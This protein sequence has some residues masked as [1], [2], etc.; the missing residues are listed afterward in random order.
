MKIES[1]ETSPR[2]GI[3]RHWRVGNLLI[4]WYVERPPVSW[5]RFDVELSVR[6]FDD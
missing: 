1:R 4:E 5:L 6:W 3:A 2:E